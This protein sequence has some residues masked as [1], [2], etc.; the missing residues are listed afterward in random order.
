MGMKTLS[1]FKLMM[2]LLHT[3]AQTFPKMRQLQLLCTEVSFCNKSN[4]QPY[5]NN[6]THCN[7][8]IIL[9]QGS[10]LMSIIIVYL[11]KYPYTPV[12]LNLKSVCS[13]GVD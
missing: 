2:I 10:H 9:T 7:L 3:L 13:E 12:L 5:S 6:V 8:S 4:D 11:F 1:P